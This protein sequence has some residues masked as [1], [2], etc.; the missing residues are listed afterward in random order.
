MQ[1]NISC[2]TLANI[3]GI[4]DAT[5]QKYSKEIGKPLP[6]HKPKPTHFHKII[7][8]IRARQDS[9]SDLRLITIENETRTLSDWA[10]RSGNTQSTIRRRL[11]YGY[12][13]QTA[14]F[15]KPGSLRGFSSLNC[16]KQD[17]YN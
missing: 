6:K 8:A 15:A 3:T 4:A 11:D 9:R 7:E 13:P 14:V 17:H 16:L 10:N 1:Q 2:H 12:P 5:L